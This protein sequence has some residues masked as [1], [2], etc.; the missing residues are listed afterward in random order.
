[1]GFTSRLAEIATGS[2]R[3]GMR[4]A[5]GKYGATAAGAVW[6]AGIGAAAG[7][8]S[9][10]GSIVGGMVAGTAIGAGG[11]LGVKTAMGIAPYAAGM[12]KASYG[13][14]KFI[15]RH[16]LGVTATAAGV[17][18]A[19]AF[20]PGALDS[21]YRGESPNMSGAYSQQT[22]AE[23][24]I[25]LRQEMGAARLMQTGIAP[26]GNVG[27]MRAAMLQQSTQGLVQGLHRSRH[28]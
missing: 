14:G 1:M 18:G 19:V 16:P 17:A 15:A 24:Q 9:E 22:P 20:G 23:A 11:A 8:Y 2:L 10:N 21:Y 26:T 28:R 12:T 3:E 5:I 13:V 27:S 25:R 7:A 4:T 6:G